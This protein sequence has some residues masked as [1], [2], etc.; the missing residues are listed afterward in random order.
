MSQSRPEISKVWVCTFWNSGKSTDSCRRPTQPSSPVS[1]KPVTAFQAPIN[2]KNDGF[3]RWQAPFTVLLT[4]DAI[5]AQ[6]SIE[7]QQQP[8]V[9]LLQLSLD[10]ALLHVALKLQTSLQ[11]MSQQQF[12]KYICTI[13]G[14]RGAAL[15]ADWIKARRALRGGCARSRL[16]HGLNVYV[17]REG[18]ASSRLMNEFSDSI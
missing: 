1:L 16:D 13:F 4:W 17:I 2:S 3:G 6:V 18:C 15:A 10:R 5:V 11:K 12:L 14:R 9:I 8:L 7:L